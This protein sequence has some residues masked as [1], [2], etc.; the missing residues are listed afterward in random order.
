M[1]RSWSVLDTVAAAVVVAG[2]TYLLLGTGGNR[3]ADFPA[4]QEKFE[5][6]G[7]RSVTVPRAALRAAFENAGLPDPPDLNGGDP[8]P[9]A[10]LMRLAREWAETRNPAALGR[11][12][13]V[14][15]ALEEH[16]AALACFAAAAELDRDEVLW[17]Y[18]LG[19]EC[20]A[21]GLDTQAVVALAEVGRVDP[22]YPTTWARLGALA[23][24]AGDV[25][26][27]AGH[28][29]QYRRRAPQ[30]SPGHIGLGRVALAR[31]ETQRAI[32]HFT[33]ATQNSPGDFLAHRFLGRALAAAGRDEAARA[34]LQLAERLPQYSGWL[35]FDPRVQ[36]SHELA[37]TQRYLTNQM[38]LAAGRGDYERFILV[39][40]RLR[41]RR[42]G[43]H[44]NLTNL[45]TVYR[46]L[47][48]L[49]DAQAT[50]DASLA[51][52]PDSPVAHCVRAEIAFARR[53]FDATH[54]ALD[55][56]ARFDPLHPKVL[57]L[58]GRTYFVQ[59]RQAEGIAAVAGS[60]EH[61]PES[62]PTRML[63]ALMLQESGR[64]DE[65]VVAIDEAVR[66]D[67]ANARARALQDSIRKAMNGS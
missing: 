33:T 38:R 2:G 16:E 31:G 34:S 8:V 21:L 62:I 37:D 45:A 24:E 43:D 19:V 12:G 6:D 40:E 10:V 30:Q 29:G 5:A 60:I 7:R 28:Y 63:L 55:D 35:I 66:R 67:P 50:I 17:R 58:R 32:E 47:G 51:L 26:A 65:A 27:A 18:G 25:D 13:Q 56:A 41:G 59:G 54:R 22:D 52:K 57:E 3:G 42:P 1:K 46:E 64:L 15:Q 14:Y 11:L 20:Q 61:D 49:H 48:R 23:L 39:A 9:V 44:G 4:L 53:D 36:A